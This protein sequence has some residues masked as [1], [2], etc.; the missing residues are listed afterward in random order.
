V[1]PWGQ[2]D[3]NDLCFG[4]AKSGDR[5][6]PIIVIYIGF[7]LGKGNFLAPLDEARAESAGDDRFI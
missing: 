6:S 2:S 3:D 5:L 4:I 1:G 7:S